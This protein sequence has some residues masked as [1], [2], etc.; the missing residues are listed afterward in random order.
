MVLFVGDDQAKDG[1]DQ[2]GGQNEQCS[3]H[4]ITFLGGMT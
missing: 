1:N 2:Q 3:C 4:E